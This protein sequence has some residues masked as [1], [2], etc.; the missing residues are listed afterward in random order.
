MKFVFPKVFGVLLLGGVSSLSCVMTG[1]IP[2][3]LLGMAGTTTDVATQERGISGT[4]NDT[5]IRAQ[6][7]NLW[8]K[9]SVDLYAH[10]LLAVQDGYVLLTGTVANEDDRLEAVKLAWQATGVKD[11][12]NEI[13][14]GVPQT[15]GDGLDDTWIST[16]V[17]S[18]LILDENVHSTNFS[19]T[20]FDG[21]VYLMGIAQNQQ[22]IEAAINIAKDTRGVKNVVSHV[23][24]KKPGD[25]P[26]EEGP[27]EVS[28]TPLSSS[29]ETSDQIDMSQEAYSDP[30]RPI[31]QSSPSSI[32]E[33]PLESPL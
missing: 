29:G 14:I 18:S 28:Q 6:I 25:D 24:I 31:S 15:V 13:K 11:V 4:F 5:D 17:R 26:K 12:F 10:V 20:T 16:K 1:C 30:E 8:F 2:I 27:S 22:E 7:N 19:V 21:I 32:Q 9:K 23:Q 3:A 33:E